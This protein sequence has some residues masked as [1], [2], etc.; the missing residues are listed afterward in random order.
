MGHDVPPTKNTQELTDVNKTSSENNPKFTQP[1]T[2]HCL[3]YKSNYVH[4]CRNCAKTTEPIL[5]L[6]TV[7]STIYTNL[8]HLIWIISYCTSTSHNALELVAEV[9][10]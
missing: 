4:I 7:M 3:M 10:D 2:S 6:A 5:N 9:A 8:A 1:S